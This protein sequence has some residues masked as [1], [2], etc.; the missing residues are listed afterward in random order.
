MCEL[1]S[2]NKG[3]HLNPTI[4]FSGWLSIIGAIIILFITTGHSSNLKGSFVFFNKKMGESALAFEKL[5][6][7]DPRIFVRL[8]IVQIA[9]T[10]I[11]NMRTN[12]WF[13]EQA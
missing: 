13:T 10:V 8:Y 9:F 2:S 7:L 4:K 12:V 1:L 5:A 3:D 11:D 6:Y